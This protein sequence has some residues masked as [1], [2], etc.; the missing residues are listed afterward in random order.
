MHP[1]EV[2]PVE[3]RPVLGIG[4]HDLAIGPPDVGGQRVAPAR[5]V[6]P[7]QHVAPEGRGSHLIQEFRGV[8]HQ[9]ADVHRAVAVDER[10]QCGGA[11]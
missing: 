9:H 6:D 11:G 2:E 5:R 4:H 7:A 1:V 10:Q 8:A 3:Q